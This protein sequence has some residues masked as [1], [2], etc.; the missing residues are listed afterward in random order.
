[1]FSLSTSPHDDVL[2]LANKMLHTKDLASKASRF[3]SLG[4]SNAN[5]TLFSLIRTICTEHALRSALG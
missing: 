1:M 2:L 3:T 5:E 4:Q